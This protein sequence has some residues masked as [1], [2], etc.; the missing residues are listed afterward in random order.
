[1]V[2]NAQ[3]VPAFNMTWRR[4]GDLLR[5]TTAIAGYRDI[6]TFRERFA[7]ELRRFITFDYVL[8]NIVDCE[9][10][11]VQWRMFH[12]PGQD[13]VPIPD[14]QP[15]ETPTTWV[16][17]NQKPV[18]ISDWERETRYARMREYF[19][20]F[21]IR[22]SCVLPLTTVHRRIGVFAVGDSRPDAYSAEA[23]QFLALVAD[24]LAVA[25]DSA[26]NLDASHQAQ[27]ELT[28]KNERGWRPCSRCARPSNSS[29]S[30]PRQYP[31]WSSGSPKQRTKSVF[32]WERTLL[33]SP[34]NV[35]LQ[36]SRFRPWFRRDC[37]H[38]SWTAVRIFLRRSRTLWRPMPS[39]GLQRLHTSPRSA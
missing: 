10:L 30:L 28:S 25:I 11:A 35:N 8:V 22:S 32:W 14:F 24:Q 19:R 15:D 34:A 29:R 4:Y 20:Q 26:L 6:R 5:A 9:T 12:A 13:Q 23:V 2:T 7:S 16:F 21:G 39:S 27:A 18:V 33:P 1:M 3:A 17:E 36:N 31:A 37:R 38:R